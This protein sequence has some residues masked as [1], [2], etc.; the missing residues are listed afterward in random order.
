VVRIRETGLAVRQLCWIEQTAG[1][2]AGSQLLSGQVMIT[3]Q[4]RMFVGSFIKCFKS[5]RAKSVA[6]ALLS[7][8]LFRAF[9][10]VYNLQQIPVVETL[11]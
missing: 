7:G 9:A 8:P 11:W 1:K 3:L 10:C 4:C 6:T 2:V 5:R